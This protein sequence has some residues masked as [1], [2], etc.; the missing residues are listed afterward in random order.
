[1]SQAPDKS[2]EVRPWLARGLPAVS[3]G[4]HALRVWQ[5][6]PCKAKSFIKGAHGL[7][8]PHE[9]MHR[10]IIAR[11][12]TRQLSTRDREGAGERPWRW[13]ATPYEQARQ[14][15]RC[16]QPRVL[17]SSSC[18]QV[19]TNF[20]RKLWFANLC[21]SAKGAKFPGAT[22]PIASRFDICSVFRIL[23]KARSIAL[24]QVASAKLKTSRSA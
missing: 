5:V 22:K 15:I 6:A 1:M 4:C 8:H 11:T 18:L 24:L 21:Y 17:P 12:R 10:H 19:A 7:R 2:C 16:A 23:A 3:C 9:N 20:A 14:R 13:Q